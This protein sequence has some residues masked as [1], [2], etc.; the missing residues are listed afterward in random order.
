MH[1]QRVKKASIAVC[2]V[3]SHGVRCRRNNISHIYYAEFWNNRYP[4]DSSYVNLKHS[5]LVPTETLFSL[6]LK[7]YIFPGVHCQS[8]GVQEAPWRLSFLHQIE[9]TFMG[10]SEQA[11]KQGPKH[12]QNTWE[13]LYLPDSFR[14]LEFIW[15]TTNS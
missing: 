3:A 4:S 1:A 11:E 12:I 15:G 5:T 6:K 2:I 8:F 10:W 9:R 13:R 14:R 7:K